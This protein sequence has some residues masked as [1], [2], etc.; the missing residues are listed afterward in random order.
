[1]DEHDYLAERFEAQRG[2]L[3]AVAYRMLGSLT[4]A[5]DAVQE[6]WL[7]L[8]RTEPAAIENF[9]GWLTTTVG[10][11]CLDTLRGRKSRREESF[12]A[13]LP[14][15]VV[16]L[17]DGC[18]PEQQAVLADSVG[19]ALL[20]VLDS[21]NP[22]ERVAFVLHDMFALPFDQIAP[23][24]DRSPAATKMLASRARRR[25]RGH[26]LP[27]APDLPRQR[28]VVDAFLSAARGGNFDALLA[29]LDPEV[30]L[31]ADAGELR[32]LTGATAVAGM[33]DTFHRFATTYDA[34]PAL[35]NGHAGLLNTF[36]GA[37]RS[38]IAFTVADDRIIALDLLSDPDRLA[39][40][41]LPA[42]PSRAR[43]GGPGRQ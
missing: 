26:T 23:I 40:L 42:V 1:M 3:T 4:E 37:P 5:E 14:D 41:P 34:T 33:L 17:D 6:S 9:G 25:V 20:V 16:L 8:A 24:L 38:I 13:R 12:E 39:R 18:G 27:G 36:E 43:H 10:R 7:R 21:L 31:R 11:V 15:P 22:A 32:V 19:M 35:V 28:R 30:V 29:I 2:H